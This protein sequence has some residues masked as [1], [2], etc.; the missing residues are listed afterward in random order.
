MRGASGV[1]TARRRGWRGLVAALLA[2]AALGSATQA[3]AQARMTLGASPAE[4]CLFP[5]VADRAKP[6]Y[7]AELLRLKQ[8]AS[9]EAEFV[10]AG[11]G[12]A[13]DVRF[14]TDPDVEYRDAVVAYA[15]QLRLP[16]MD[17]AGA[18]VTLKQG[19]DF[20]PN[21]G[22]KVAWTTPAE[23]LDSQR[24]EQLKCIV[25]DAEAR[26]EYPLDMVRAGRQG[27]VVA[28]IRFVASDRPPEVEILDNGGGHHFGDNVVRMAATMRMPCLRDAPVEM[29]MHYRFIIDGASRPVL[30]DLDLKS[31]LATVKPVAPGSAFF[32]TRTMKCPFDVRLT[33]QQPY[34]P[35]L[36]AELEEDVPARHAFLDWMAQREFNIAARSSN[37]LL[38]QQMTV[39]IPCATIDL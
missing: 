16:C 15:K 2:I 28:R 26:P 4:R 22:R 10:F 35:N 36:V 11:P 3:E 25:S 19:F 6:A 17:K 34:E 5:A 18:P 39:H 8:G 13:P 20:V 9:F 23:P 32:D 24:R 38:G 29:M 31:F 1:T 27:T 33:W 12:T 21:D 7:P 37:L 30:G 14:P